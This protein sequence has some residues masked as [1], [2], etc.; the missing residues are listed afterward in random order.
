M[1]HYGINLAEGSEITNL[2][3]D[4]GDVFPQNPNEGELFYKTGEGLFVHN[5]T[6]WVNVAA[7]N[8]SG[9]IHN[10]TSNSTTWN[11][12]HN[13]GTTNI[14]VTSYVNVNDVSCK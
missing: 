2:T 12:Q 7:G 1:K 10:Q 13:L 5:G 4:V 9:Y 8:T 11:I 14:Q 3:V 6:S